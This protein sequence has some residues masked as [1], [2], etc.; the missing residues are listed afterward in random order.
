MPSRQLLCVAMLMMSQ[1][2]WGDSL[3]ADD[4]VPLARGPEDPLPK[5]ALGRLGSLKFLP[6]SDRVTRIEYSPDGQYVATIATGDIGTMNPGVQIW[7]RRTGRECT[8]K[9]LRDVDA[10]GFCW[11]P[12]RQSF[13]TSHR[14]VGTSNTLNLWKIGVEEPLGFTDAKP[15]GFLSVSCSKDGKRVAALS[16]ANEVIVFDD[17]GRIV[18]QFPF[19]GTDP[20]L[21]PS[22]PVDFTANGKRLAILSDSGVDMAELDS[23]RVAPVKLAIPKKSVTKLLCLPDGKSLAIPVGKAIEIHQTGDSPRLIR[24]LEAKTFTDMA[25]SANGKWLAGGDFSGTVTV[26]DVQTGDRVHVSKSIAGLGTGIAFSP[27]DTELCLGSRRLQFLKVGDWTPVFT[28][29]YALNSLTSVRVINARL[30]TGGNSIPLLE[31]SL[32]SGKL[33]RVIPG[34]S[35]P[36]TTLCPLEENQLAISGYGQ[37]AIRVVDLQTGKTEFTLPGH[38]GF[39]SRMCYSARR[40]QLFS[41]G[42]DHS[43]KVW[44]VDTQRISPESPILIYPKQAFIPRLAISSNGKL[45]AS[46]PGISSRVDVVQLSN[47]TLKFSLEQ[48]KEFLTI[49]PVVFSPN[50]KWLASVVGVVD[51]QRKDDGAMSDIRLT[52]SHTGQEIGRLACQANII[53]DISIS[54]DN[55]YLVAAVSV[56]SPRLQVWSLTS[57]KKVADVPGHFGAIRDICFSPDGRKLI[58][59]SEDTTGLIWDFEALVRDAKIEKKS[60]P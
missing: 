8:P 11:M 27:D 56:S 19:R 41:T 30:Y 59:V 40:G 54:P 4:K 7:E 39:T 33:L 20:L 32:E 26:W 50:S 55:A 17:R 57:R 47:R 35:A 2:T 45:L 24:K 42:E 12:R 52:D 3:R 25:V 34:V 9:R 21:I 18:R 37:S 23:G 48:G 6:K 15:Q 46:T 28:P 49:A 5:Y 36:T 53:M 16:V 31:W 22:G 60:Q 1:V 58:S 43:I 44:D 38:G 29:E 14:V 10:T 13:L 51:P